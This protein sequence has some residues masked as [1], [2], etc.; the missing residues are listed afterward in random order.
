MDGIKK[1]AIYLPLSCVALQSLRDL[2]SEFF[3]YP[4]IMP[5]VTRENEKKRAKTEATASKKGFGGFLCGEVSVYFVEWELQIGEEIRF[6][7]IL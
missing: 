1:S 2:P 5:I 6:T 4:K 7:A 3:P